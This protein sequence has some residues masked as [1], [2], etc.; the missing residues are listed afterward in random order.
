MDFSFN[1]KTTNDF[2][3]ATKLEW[4]ETNGLG[5]Y[6]SST[7]LG[8]NTRRYHGLLVAATQPPVGRF[9]VLSKLE[10]TI[11][12][13]G[14]Q[15]E[16]GTNQYPNSISPKGFVHLKAFTKGL[17][18][19]F[20]YQIPG[21]ELKK[22]IC[23][24]HGENTIVIL[25]EVLKSKKPF[26]LDLMPLVANRDYHNLVHSNNQLHAYA[27]YERGVFKYNPYKGTPDLYISVPNGKYVVKPYWFY[28]FEYLEE[29]SRGMSFKEDLFTPG[30]FELEV[31]QGDKIAVIVSTENIEGKDGLQ[32][33]NNEK[34]RR[35]KLLES[36]KSGDSF[37][38]K[39]TLAADQF[40]VKRNEHLKT[41]IAGYHWFSD[42]GRDTMISLPGICLVTKRYDDAR[43]ILHAFANSVDMGMIPNRFPDSGEE[44]EYNTVDAT[45]WF[46]HA[47]YK[48]LKYSRD[49]IFVKTELMPVFKDILDWHFK[50]TRYN[51]KVEEDGLLHSGQHGVQLTWMDA[52]VGDW[53]VTPREGKAVEINALWYNALCIYADFCKH[54]GRSEEAD[55]YT[56]KAKKVKESFNEKFWNESKGCLYD[57]VSE[58]HKDDKIRPNQIF[59]LSLPFPLVS[60]T[61]AKSVLKIVEEKLLTPVGLRS[62][63]PDDPDYQPHYLGSQLQRDGAYHQGTVWSWLMGPYIDALIAVKGKSGERQAKRIIKK[64][65]YH[66]AEAGIGS[67]SE[68]F[69]AEPPFAPKGCIA[70]AWGVAEILRV[71]IQY[72]LQETSRSIPMAS[73]VK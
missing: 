5:G 24:I 1:R 29:L 37:L 40:I 61:K 16:L 66:L 72:K 31:K 58:Y 23:A 20:T 33:F 27:T 11:H 17:F 10:E 70:Q 6:S 59:A 56:E 46:F 9:V 22:T 26:R 51:I 35:L 60:G 8:L 36:L 65:E 28:N 32:L 57:V 63:A 13:N 41:I 68:I 14:Q 48:Y 44:P 62:L 38:K 52:K 34:K 30:Q 4:L 12:L 71:Y 39:L 73:V 45:L 55:E 21:I 7:I 18:P 50:G 64:F 47:A 54:F 15:F 42:W 67:V 49:D 69:D 3:I 53:V 2:N 19:E 43:K 25:Y